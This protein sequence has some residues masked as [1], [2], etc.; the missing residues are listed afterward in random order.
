MTSRRYLPALVAAVLLAIVAATPA[1]GAFTAGAGSPANQAVAA[2]VFKPVNVTPPAISGTAREGEVLTASPGNWNRQPERFT[3]QWQRCNATATSCSAI[4]GATAQSYT[5]TPTDR[6]TRLVVVVTAINAGGSASKTS[7][8]T[9]LVQEAQK[10]T[11]PSNTALPTISG[12]L[13]DG[14]TL[15]STEGTWGGDPSTRAF[16]WLRCDAAGSACSAIAGATAATYTLTS[17]DVA[18]RL[19]TRVTATNPGGS[20]IAESAP[21]A[22][23]RPTYPAAVRADNPTGYWRMRGN[24]LATVGPNA[25]YGGGT[26][27][28]PTGPISTDP[29][30]QAL[31]LP[32]GAWAALPS[33]T[34]ALASTIELWFRTTTP[35]GVIISYTQ[36]RPDGWAAGHIPVLYIGTDGLVRAGAYDTSS[37]VVTGPRA[38]DGNWHHAVIQRSG[39]TMTFRFDGNLIGSAGGGNGVWDEDSGWWSAAGTGAAATQAWP[40]GCRDTADPCFY[41]GDIDELAAYNYAV[42]AARL[43]AHYAAAR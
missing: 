27:S 9:S 31:G 18:A 35:G 2:A 24:L 21:T 6:D 22:A 41:R 5:A 14:H 33:G 16:Q 1:L 28:W 30:D 34:L 40:G 4:A 12:T 13:T 7:P 19:R 3:Y 17:A 37:R 8:P 15:T 25:S 29:G 42:S 11:P 39:N 38:T 10:F 32:T 20:A 43:N 26:Y 23:I 36:N